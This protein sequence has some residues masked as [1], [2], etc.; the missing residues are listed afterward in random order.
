MN[1]PQYARYN[2]CSEKACEFIEKYDI[3]SFPINPLEII[4]AENYG[5]MK[6]SELMEEYNCSLDKVCTCMRSSDGKT[7]L[8]NGY[9]SIAYN[10]FKSPTRIRFTLMHELGHIFLNHL[11][12]FEATEMLRNDEFT[13]G[14]TKHEYR[15]LENEA[16]AFARNVL[17]PVS[18]YL[19]L[20]DKS[21]DNVAFTFGISSSAAEARIDFINRDTSI[22]KYLNLS[23]KAMLVYRRFMKKQKCKVCDVQLYNKYI[24]CPICGSKNTL[25][26]GD[27]DMKKYPLLDTHENGKLKECPVCE[28]A[29]TDIDGDYCQICGRYIVNK[30]SNYDCGI[31]L[32]SNAR[33]CP[34]CGNNSVF[35]NANILKAWDYKEPDGFM[36]IPDIDE[37]LPF[38]SPNTGNGF[39]VILPPYISNDYGIPDG[40]DEELP[41]N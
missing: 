15:V 16:N 33:F 19:T 7:I 23:Q 25:Q 1:I 13:T 24:Y 18:M 41:F 30:C 34:V 6:Y 37:E 28:N 2:Y 9:Y 26:W 4:T 8:E 17:A 39:G 32:P 40:I 29:E 36:T 35:F 5:I 20:K 11:M 12:D 3:K 14:L 31:I 22:I 10:D 27:G 21:I 38:D